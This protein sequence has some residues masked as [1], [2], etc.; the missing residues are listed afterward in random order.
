MTPTD[1]PD[2]QCAACL[3]CVRFGI[4]IESVP[5]RTQWV[6]PQCVRL[7]AVVRRP[8][9]HWRRISSSA[10]SG[11]QVLSP[12]PIDKTFL[13]AHLLALFS[14]CCTE[15]TGDMLAQRLWLMR[16]TCCK[17]RR[18]ALECCILRWHRSQPRTGWCC[19]W[20]LSLHASLCLGHIQQTAGLWQARPVM[21]SF[22][23]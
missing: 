20:Y 11:R 14:G 5:A 16:C 4:T 17:V 15:V 22:A 7:Q 19:V 6:D 8:P 10:S 2:L 1:S 23:R 18:S 12:S 21:Q 3:D 9:A 13:G